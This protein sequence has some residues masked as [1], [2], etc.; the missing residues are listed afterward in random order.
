MRRYHIALLATAV[1]LPASFLASPLKFSSMRQ[2]KTVVVPI[3]TSPDSV[4]QGRKSFDKASILSSRKAADYFHRLQTQNW[5]TVVPDSAGVFH[6]SPASS[7]K[8]S[9][10]A[11]LF[12][13]ATRLRPSDFVKGKLVAKSASML[14]VFVDGKSV[15]KKTSVDSIPTEVKAPLTLQPQYTSEIEVHLLA[16]SDSEADPSLSICFV[17]DS[18]FDNV[19]IAEG[20]DTDRRFS[21]ATTTE[22]ARVTSTQISPDGKYLI[23]GFSETYG[24]KDSRAWTELRAVASGATISSSLPAGCRWM[25]QGAT[26]FF[27]ERTSNGFSLYSMPAATM[28]R[29]LIA[30]DVPVSAAEISWAPDASWF[31]YYSSEKGKKEDGVMRRITEQDDRIPGTRDRNYLVRYDLASGVSSQLTFGGP[32]TILTDI[33]PDSKKILYTAN[34][35]VPGEFPFYNNALIQLDVNSLKTDTIVAKSG[36]LLSAIYSPDGKKVLM[37]GSPNEFDK[38]GLNA[39]GRDW[40]NDFDVQA[41]L[42]DIATRKPTALTRDFNPSINGAPVWNKKD[43]QIYFKASDGF[44][45]RLYSLNPS[46][47]QV[48]QLPVNVD[49]VNNFSVG[50]MENRWLAYFGMSY[51]SIG[52]CWLLDLK[53]GKNTLVADPM[54]EEYASLKLGEVSEWKFTSANGDVID[55]TMTLPPDFDPSRKYPLIVYY[56]GGTTPSVRASHNPYTPQLFASRGYVVYVVNPSG[57]IGYGQEFSARHINAW[58]DMTADEIIEGVKKF[59]DEHPF[60]DS[61]KIGCLGASYGGFMTQLLQT[62]TD[63]FAAAIS[64]AG[65]SNVTSYWGEG[66]WGYSYNSVAAARS[67]PWSD[68]DLFTK[69]G[70]LFNADKIH[71]PLL[72]LHGSRD[73]NVPI[74]ES[75]QIFNALKILGRDVEFIS[76]D[77]QDHIITDYDKRKLW[78]ATIMAWFAKY[79]KDDPRWW[80]SMYGD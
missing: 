36:G 37:W 67:Y 49:Y 32:S 26:L 44:Y 57:T 40:G 55:G 30:P 59:C 46:T 47:L 61:K 6:L 58:G 14:E 17:P 18:G 29:S 31:A 80:N 8:C 63:I 41:Y 54:G 12:T 34:K 4:D 77:D 39:P 43:G 65:I 38:L 42:I 48:K 53:S 68:P 79:L 35:T 50:D 11:N 19:E 7:C 72:L 62:K 75:V 28:S 52:Q 23:V 74:G 24:E 56:Y 76:V 21:L 51:T 2:D 71:T 3:P 16:M 15:L 27:T 22:G 10:K 69:K 73:T 9:P 60:V 70:S 20:P 64:H 5:T 13:L 78:H 45:V 33:S 1:A 25:P 66:Y